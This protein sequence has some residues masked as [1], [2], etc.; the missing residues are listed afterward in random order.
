M[1]LFR[2]SRG[3]KRRALQAL[4]SRDLHYSYFLEFGQHLILSFKI[5]QISVAFRY[6]LLL[7]NGK[8]AWLLLPDHIL[9]RI[10]FE[11]LRSWLPLTL[12]RG[13]HRNF[14]KLT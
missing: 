9:I 11:H 12:P 2:V 7:D 6:A 4:Q 13:L 8:Q 10:A 5:S 3:K 1:S 14:L